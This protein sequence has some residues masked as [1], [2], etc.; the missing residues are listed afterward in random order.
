MRARLWL[1]VLLGLTACD[2]DSGTGETPTPDTGVTP[3]MAA[4]DEGTPTD[5]PVADAPP[6]QVFGALAFD[7]TEVEFGTVGVGGKVD[8][9]LRLRNDGEG[10]LVVEGWTL[11]APFSSSRQPPLTIPPGGMRTLLLSFEPEEAG[12]FE[13]EMTFTVNVP[14]AMPPSV[15]LRGEAF[16]AEGQLTSD[17]VDFGVIAPGQPSAEFILV[18]NISAVAPLTVN[19]VDGVMPPFDVPVGQVPVTVEP[20]QTAMVLVQF[21]PQMDGAFEQLVTVRTN[22]G[23][24]EVTLTGRALSVG[25]LTV[26]GAEPAWAPTDA[27]T[28]IT[29]HGGPFPALPDA[30]RVG[31]Q[32]LDFLE[33]VDEERVRGTLPAGGEPGPVDVRVE[34]GGAFGIRPGGLTRTGPVAMGG[35]LDADALAGGEIG[36]DGNPWRLA[37]DTIPAEMELAVATGTVI[38]CDG[39]SLTVEGVLRAGGDP[40]QVV[41]STEA[42]TPGSWGGIVLSGEGAASSLTDTILEYGGS[43]GAMV[44]SSQGASLARVALRQSSG[45]GVRVED[46]GTLVVQGGDFTDLGGDAIVVASGATIFRLLMTRIRRAQWPMTAYTHQFPNPLGAA[47]DWAGNAHA[48]IGL[49]GDITE[50]VTLGNQPAGVLFELV[51]PINVAADATLRFASAAPL[52]LNNTLTV[53]G[54]LELPTGLRVRTGAGG[55]LEVRDGAALSIQGIPAEPVVFEARD[56]D[57]DARPGAWSGIHIA[58][59]VDIAAT[60]LIVRDAGEGDT[61]ALTLAADFG[62]LVG[63]AVEDSAAVGLALSGTGN[64]SS[65]QLNGNAGATRI[66]GGSG[67]IAGTTTDPAPAVRFDGVGCDAWDVSELLDGADLPASSD[68]E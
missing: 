33:L 66:T 30:V 65:A 58:A 44:F 45:D 55:R 25:D 41:F 13:V 42:G 61:A 9:M 28:V 17:R 12:T 47:H 16:T 8:G 6:A 15:T 37:T 60:R 54:R 34:M 38:L 5:G 68:C 43:E 49:R 27:A 56:P 18:E 63:L 11:P 31:D 20:G 67:S 19:A 3:D 7:A 48:S 24:W 1:L 53:D 29:V 23:E 52:L 46:G 26:I 21:D 39:R 40:G 62:D 50:D 14:G 59:G 64:I 10:E 35:M 51:D 36:P 4:A 32:V 2:D 22:G 57:G